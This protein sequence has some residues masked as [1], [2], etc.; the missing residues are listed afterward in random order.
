MKTV[1]KILRAPHWLVSAPGLIFF[2]A[3]WNLCKLDEY[4]TVREMFARAN[5][6]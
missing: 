2:W 5:W 1:F 6:P 3:V 4:I